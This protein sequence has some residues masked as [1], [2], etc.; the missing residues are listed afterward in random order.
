MFFRSMSARLFSLAGVEGFASASYL[1]LVLLCFFWF[2]PIQAIIAAIAITLSIIIH[3]F[4]HAMVCRRYGLGPTIMLH[5]LGGLCYH[6]PASTDGREALITVA[7][8]LVQIAVGLVALGVLFFWQPSFSSP[9]A[10]GVASHGL[11]FLQMFA[12]FS[13]FWGSVNLV[14]P[15]WPLDGGKLFALLLRRFMSE[16]RARTWAL[17]VSMAL[18]LPL[19]VWALYSR[20]FL[21]GFIAI[22]TLIDNW[23][24][25]QSGSPLF[26]HGSGKGG[27]QREKKATLS[28]FAEELIAEAERAFANREWREAARL[29]HQLRATNESIPPKKM[30]RVWE[31]LGIATLRSGEPEEAIAWLERAPQTGE[32]K[33]A[34]A[35][36][37]QRAA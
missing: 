37:K 30:A 32:V 13:L 16:E 34:L 11:F 7:G 22:S 35:E 29:M 6:R 28:P 9:L 3:E 1:L 12:W 31:I 21:L 18:L 17:R 26:A 27:T 2:S 36:A 4:G 23:Q 10:I 15:I 14:A 33:Q 20:S 19:G 8:P 25:M 24:I 5:G